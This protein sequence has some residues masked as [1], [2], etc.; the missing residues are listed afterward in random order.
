MKPRGFLRRPLPS[1]SP[2]VTSPEGRG[3]PFRARVFA[4][5]PPF[6]ALRAGFQRTTLSHL[7]TIRWLSRAAERFRARAA[8]RNELSLVEGALSAG[9]KRCA[10]KRAPQAD[11]IDRRAVVSS[12]R[13][14]GMCA[15]SA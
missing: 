7:H 1:V 12:A 4:E 11:A 9:Q 15:P 6:A 2:R 13:A 5:P 8:V 10:R 3:E 14:R